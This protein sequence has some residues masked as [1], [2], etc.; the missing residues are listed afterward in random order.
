VAEFAPARA[1]IP[2]S[3]QRRNDDR[4]LVRFH[5][6]GEVS[7]RVE[8]AAPAA[9][10]VWV[11]GSFGPRLAVEIDGREVGSV[12]RERAQPASWIRLDTLR[13]EAGSHRVTVRG[14]ASPIAPGDGGPTSVGPVVLRR[15]DKAPAV[16]TVPA[17]EWRRLCGRRLSSASAVRPA[18]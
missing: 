18:A 11:R 9:Y 15:Q 17:R 2:R 1:D 10:A 12:R 14:D 6:D 7:G 4:S 5:G 13:L 16:A 3:W 8:V